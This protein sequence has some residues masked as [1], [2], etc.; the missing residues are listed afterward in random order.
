MKLRWE[1]NKYY[2]FGIVLDVNNLNFYEI[3]NFGKLLF[4]V[5][6]R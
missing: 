5:I 2:V 4:F 3:G 6:F 1:K